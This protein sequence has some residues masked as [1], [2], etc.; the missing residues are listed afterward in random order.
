ME[1]LP[2]DNI[3]LSTI[4]LLTEGGHDVVRA[5]DEMPGSSDRQV[6][7]QAIGSK[8]ILLP[9]AR[10]YGELIFELVRLYAGDAWVLLIT[11]ELLYGP[12]VDRR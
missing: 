7:E 6:I 2:N 10:D 11:R 8:R 1:F 9:H 12:F 3:P 5:A 4:R